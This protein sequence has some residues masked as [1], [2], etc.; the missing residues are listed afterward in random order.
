[1]NERILIKW[2]SKF[3]YRTCT[4]RYYS[5]MYRQVLVSTLSSSFTPF[6]SLLLSFMAYSEISVPIDL[7]FSV[8]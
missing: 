7:V 4:F 1:M 2:L 6:K 8:L 5:K 3:N